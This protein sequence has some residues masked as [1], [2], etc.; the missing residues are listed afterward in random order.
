[1]RNCFSKLLVFILIQTFALPYPLVHAVVNQGA[2]ANAIDATKLQSAQPS[3]DSIC[4]QFK[5]PVDAQFCSDHGVPIEAGLAPNVNRARAP[6]GTCNVPLFEGENCTQVNQQINL[7]KL[8]NSQVETQCAAYTQADEVGP[9]EYTVL[10]LDMAA[11]GICGTVCASQWTG[12]G[13]AAAPACSAAGCA[14]SVGQIAAIVKSTESPV[15][16]MFQGLMTGAGAYTAFMSS[17][18]YCGIGNRSENEV[19]REWVV[20]LS[21]L[22]IKNA[23]AADPP[24]YGWYNGNTSE[25]IVEETQGTVGGNTTVTNTLPNSDFSHV[26]QVLDK[27]NSYW[28]GAEHSQVPSADGML[29]DPTQ[30]R[31]MPTDNT[32]RFF[33]NKGAN[34]PTD[35]TQSAGGQTDQ[36][37]AD[38][39]MACVSA[40][41]FAVLAGLRYKNIDSMKKTKDDACKSVT[42]LASSAAGTMPAVSQVNPLFPSGGSSIRGGGGFGT[43]GSSVGGG[44]ASFSNAAQNGLQCIQA[45]GLTNCAIGGA[46]TAGAM[47]ANLLGRS[48]LDRFAAPMAQRLDFNGLKKSIESGNA[49]AGGLMAGATGGGS[50]AAGE[51]GKGLAT[52]AQASFESKIFDSIGLGAGTAYAG[53]GGGGGG[54]A[55]AGDGGMVAALGGLFGGGEH[56]GAG[57][58]A[59]AAFANFGNKQADIWH[60]GSP[61]NIFQIVS[62]KIQKVNYRVR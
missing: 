16:K 57:S 20:L 37:K 6:A 26:Q 59:A 51:F 47:D 2:N 8:K 40:A 5:Q 7:C 35:A 60:A 44:V 36:S 10:G 45:Q 19:E 62:D 27:P 55:P 28:S 15:S 25:K 50:G 30:L 12:F 41:M 9:L 3:C 32:S 33:D 46:S 34:S 11:A 24:G 14:A 52:L 42:Q 43:G 22:L 4:E 61:M 58:Q 23:H 54:R 18:G 1:M 31:K 21:M 29:N 17:G 38:A 13:A 53:G 56:G 48:G 49:T 39:K